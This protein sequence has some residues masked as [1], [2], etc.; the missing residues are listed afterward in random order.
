MKSTQKSAERFSHVNLEDVKSIVA[1]HDAFRGNLL[2]ILHEV[3]A[4]Y[5]Y[6][7]ESALEIIADE[8][9]IPV[10][11]V[12]GTATF[13]TLFSIIP[14]G[15][16]VIK[17]CNSAPCHIGGSKAILSAIKDELDIEPG[18]MT[19]DGHFSLELTSCLGVCGVGPVIMIDDD[20][21][22]NLT[23]EKIPEI[24]ARYR[25]EES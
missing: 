23:P 19:E 3:Q 24:L 11:E 18:E 14:K 15:T 7:P 6:L 13:Y 8:L 4:K 5:G 12:Y 21:Y 25:Q 10:S 2:P 9:C 20:I 22:G 1:K 17:V 16:H